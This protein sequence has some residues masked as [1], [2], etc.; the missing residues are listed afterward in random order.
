M[1]VERMARAR[2]TGD[3]STARQR[4]SFGAWASRARVPLGFVLAALFI[5]RA[6]PSPWTLAIGLPIA[7]AGLALRAAAAGH[8]RKNDVLA[9]SG[10]YRYTRNPLYLGSALLALGFVIAAA[11]WLL[12][13]LAAAMLFVIYLPVIRREEA[14]LAARFGAEFEAF[15]RTVPRLLPRFPPA[16]RTAEGGGFSWRLYW[17]HREYNALLGFLALAAVVVLKWLGRG[18]IP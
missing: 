5:W 17:R 10:P 14:F 4:R 6:H 12:A 15:R 9:V 18:W 7:A 16:P 2:A 3:G 1:S 13:A 8:I 11:S